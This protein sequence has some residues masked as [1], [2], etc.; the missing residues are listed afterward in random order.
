VNESLQKEGGFHSNLINNNSSN[1]NKNKLLTGINTQKLEE[2]IISCQD[3]EDGGMS[4]R[5]GNTTDI[6]HTFFGLAAL[7][8][9]DHEKYNLEQ[10]DALFAIPKKLTKDFRK[11]IHHNL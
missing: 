3:E 11:K 5:P 10:I 1:P 4:D 9:I 6:F 8:L 2:F 7:S